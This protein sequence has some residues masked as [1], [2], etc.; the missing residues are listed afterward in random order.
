MKILISILVCMLT[1]TFAMADLTGA[2]SKY[3]CGALRYRGTMPMGGLKYS[4]LI[5]G[6]KKYLIS[7]QSGGSPYAPVKEALKLLNSSRGTRGAVTEVYYSGD[8]NVKIKSTPKTK[9]AA[10]QVVISIFRASNSEWAASCL[11]AAR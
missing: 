11:K 6:T 7:A 8:I 10:A 1:S 9:T 3:L 5:E 4:V 2:S